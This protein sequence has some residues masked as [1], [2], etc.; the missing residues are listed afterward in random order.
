MNAILLTTAN[1]GYRKMLFAWMCRARSLGLKYVVHCQDTE[2]Y[3]FL[4]KSGGNHPELSFFYEESMSGRL[5]STT[6]PRL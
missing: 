6:C 5:G 2:L 1:Y 4:A 3:D